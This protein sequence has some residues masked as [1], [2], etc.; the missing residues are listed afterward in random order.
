[1]PS[2]LKPSNPPRATTRINSKLENQVTAYIAAAGAAS[3]SLLALASSAEAKVVYT[4]TNVNVQYGTTIDLNNDGTPDFRFNE[5]IMYH[6]QRL[7]IQPAVA[8]NGIRFNGAGAACGFF[9]VPVGPGETFGTNTSYFKNGV[10]VAGFFQYSHSSFHGPFA[11]AV[12]RYLGLKFL[13]DGQVHFGWARL[14]IQNNVIGALMTGYAY[15]T[16]PNVKII[17]GHTSGTSASNIPPSDLL[18]PSSRPATLGMLARGADGLAIW[19]REED[20]GKN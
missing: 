10:F 12:N 1:M 17:E 20:A 11:N 14:T 19:R 13:I 18:V 4:P 16:E 6:S 5:F 3:V 2:G 8:G 7:T 9:G 15:E